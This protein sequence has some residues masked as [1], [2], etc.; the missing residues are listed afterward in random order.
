MDLNVAPW[1]T[2]TLTPQATLLSVILAPRIASEMAQAALE[3]LAADDPVALASTI[4]ATRRGL[5][6]AGPGGTASDGGEM[7][8]DGGS[9]AAAPP[10]APPTPADPAR[11]VTAAHTRAAALVALAAAAARAKLMADAQEAE[12]E[13][14]TRQVLKAQ[15]SRVSIKTKYLEQIEKVH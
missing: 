1:C 8:V 2:L 5:E 14:L 11:P 7:E 3:A 9:G 12:M 4:E 15:L 10:T 6:Q 13:K